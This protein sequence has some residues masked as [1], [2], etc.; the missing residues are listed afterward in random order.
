MR[1]F[2]SICLLAAVFAAAGAQ[3]LKVSVRNDN[4]S[5]AYAYVYVNGKAAAVTDTAGVALIPSGKWQVGDTLSAT[6]VGS[7]PDQLV[8]DRKTA[9]Q[10]NC[11]LILSEMYT[12]TADEV[13]VKADLER[14]FRKTVKEVSGCI[15]GS[16]GEGQYEADVTMRFG[17][18]TGSMHKA[19]GRIT[20]HRNAVRPRSYADWNYHLTMESEEPIK[21]FRDALFLE[22]NRMLKFSLSPVFHFQT[23][24]LQHVKRHLGYLGKKNGCRIFRVTFP[25]VKLWWETPEPMFIQIIAYVD[26]QT[27]YLRS[28]EA[29]YLSE[30]LELAC[31]MKAEYLPYRLT[32][33]WGLGRI[34]MVPAILTYQI[35]RSGSVAE[36]TLSNARFIS[37]KRT[38]GSGYLYVPVEPK[39]D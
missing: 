2:V 38:K 17:D 20:T 28:V 23:K 12:L 3:N 25:V 33:G 7:T 1:K 21:E 18:T 39:V 9:K 29:E 35:S 26:E 36:G 24:E 32:A 15:D 22:I 27:K 37:P 4:E 34:C 14:L 19:A 31:K 30:G 6:Y 8:L 13:R 5:L 16:W 11:E 10:G